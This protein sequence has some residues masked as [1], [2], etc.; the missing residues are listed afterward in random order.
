MTFF[1]F[2]YLIAINIHTIL[3]LLNNVKKE[4]KQ[5]NKVTEAAKE[6]NT[7]SNEIR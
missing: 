1:R 5:K 2:L 7:I 4:Q 6:K 3:L